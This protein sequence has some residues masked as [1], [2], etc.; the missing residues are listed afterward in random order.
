VTEEL[1]D[2]ASVRFDRLAHDL[3]VMVHQA[4][5]GLGIETFVQRRRSD[6]VG[7]D[8]RDDL[9]SD[10]IAGTSS[11]PPGQ[12]R[13]APTA[14]LLAGL[15]RCP[16]RRAG[17]PEAAAA[18]RAEAAIRTITVTARRA[19]DVRLGLHDSPALGG[20]RSFAGGGP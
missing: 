1:D 17:H 19:G 18:L 20:R 16:A 5:D 14:E 6:Q 11:V 13:A 9:A 8:D 4:A 12:S 7:E 15:N 3:V 2:A 10:G